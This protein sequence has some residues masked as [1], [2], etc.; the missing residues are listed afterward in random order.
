[1]ERGALYVTKTS[2]AMTT[3]GKRYLSRM[4]RPA[5][6]QVID[7]RTKAVLSAV[8]TEERGKALSAY[9]RASGKR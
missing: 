3:V 7:A 2:I 1:M 6:D 5:Q 8:A 9:L 4:H